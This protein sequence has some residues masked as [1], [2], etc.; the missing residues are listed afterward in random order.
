MDEREIVRY[1][2]EDLDGVEA[3]TANGDWFF[4]YDPERKL[5]H[6][7]RMPFATLVTGDL[8]DHASNLSREGVFRLNIGVGKETYRSLFGDPPAPAGETG[9]VE[10]GHDFTALD[11]IMPHPVYAPQ[12]WVC[13]LNPGESTVD[14]VRSLLT[15]AHT[16]AARSYAIRMAQGEE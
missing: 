2:S 13:V 8:Y 11:Q 3:V 5:P 10:T 1:L 16:R 7:R 6:D 15:E 12:H 14:T 9:V 4:F